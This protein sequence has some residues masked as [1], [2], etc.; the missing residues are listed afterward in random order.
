MLP[1]GQSQGQSQATAQ[2][3]GAG[4]DVPTEQTLKGAGKRKQ[5]GTKAAWLLARRASDESRRNR[6][7][8]QAWHIYSPLK[9]PKKDVQQSRA[10][11]DE[12]GG[13]SGSNDVSGR[14]H[15]PDPATTLRG[16]GTPITDR[17]SS[18]LLRQREASLGSLQGLHTP[19]IEES[20]DSGTSRTEEWVHGAPGSSGAREDPAPE[21]SDVSPLTEDTRPRDRLPPKEDEDGDQGA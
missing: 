17:I 16:D 14:L 5:D 11:S 21:D 20:P 12:S 3:D 18:P 15:I 10:R 6:H 9:D 7:Q 13:F 8:N 2:N 4:G 1:L 19:S